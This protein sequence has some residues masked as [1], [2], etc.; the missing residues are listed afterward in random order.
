MALHYYEDFRSRDEENHAYRID[1][2]NH[3]SYSHGHAQIFQEGEYRITLNGNKHLLS[4]PDL[5]D[6][7]L[8]MKMT[9]AFR[10]IQ[11][12]YG[13]VW[14]FRYDRKGM[15]GHKLEMQFDPRHDMK[16]LLDGKTIGERSFGKLPPSK[17]M[18]AVLEVKGRELSFTAFGMTCK[19][20]IR[21]K[22]FPSAGAV[23]FDMLFSP[24]STAHIYSVQ[25]DSPD[26][27][28]SRKPEKTIEFVLST[29]QGMTEPLK[30][31]FS[32][33]PCGADFDQLDCVLDGSIRGRGDREDG[34][35]RGWIYEYDYLTS[36]YIR[37]ESEGK[38]L[39]NF[40]FR[41]GC[42]VLL[43]RDWKNYANRK[44]EDLPWPLHFTFIRRKL[45]GKYLVAAG[46]E[47]EKHKPW[48]FCENGPWEQIRDQEGNF[49]YEGPSL[50]K[51]SVALTVSSPEDKKIVSRIPRGI[52]QYE[53]ALKHAREQH[54]FYDDEKISFLL[55]VHYRKACYFRE[56][57]SLAC[58]VQDPYGTTVPGVRVRLTDADSPAGDPSFACIGK[59]AVLNKN[60]PC[61]IYHL[62]LL[63]KNGLKTFYDDV[64]IF[65][66]L[67]EDPAGPPPPL[68][69]GLP[70]MIS[71]NNEIKNLESDGFDPLGGWGGMG[72]YYT[73]VMR[74]PLVGGRLKIWELLKVYHR[75]WHLMLTRRNAGDFSLENEFNR[76]LIR[77]ADFLDKDVPEW[78]SHIGSLFLYRRDCHCGPFL[79]IFKEFLLKKKPPL[80]LTTPEI[81]DEMLSSDPKEL[82]AF[83]CYQRN[84]LS[85][86]QF[87][88]L[89]NTCWNEWVDFAVKAFRKRS[90]AFGKELLKINPKL[91]RGSYGPS[92]LYV[93]HYKSAYGARLAVRSHEYDEATNRN[94]SYFFIEE[95]HLSCD[96]TI[97]RSSYFIANCKL[98]RPEMRKLFPEIY[99]GGGLGCDD[100]AVYQAHPP[101]G[102]YDC[103]PQH[104]RSIVY[105][106]CYATPYFKNGKFD[107]WRDYGF[108]CPTPDKA[109]FREFIHAWG[110]LHRNPPARQLAAPFFCYDFRLFELLGD[111]HEDEYNFS[112]V[113]G[114]LEGWSDVV[115]TGEEAM[116]YAFIELTHNGYN[117]PVQTTFE[118]LS[119]L[120]KETAPFLVLP[121]IPEG[122]P[123]KILK[124]IRNAHKKGIGLL[125]FEKVC[126]LEDLFGVKESGKAKALRRIGE[127]VFHHK[128]AVASYVA[129]GAKVVK[130]G[131]ESVNGKDDVP[132][133]FF[134]ETS[135]GRT[136]L[137]NVPPTTVKRE[138]YRA[139]LG[140]GQDTLSGEMHDC[141]MQAASFLMPNP[142]SKSELGMLNAC[143]SEKGDVIVTVCGCTPAYGVTD[144]YPRSF[145]FKVSFPGIGK[146]GIETEA[147]FAV[148]KREKDSL[149]IRTETELDAGLFFRFVLKERKQA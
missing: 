94:G 30:F 87:D 116:G 70:M 57:F 114:V 3:S 108:H 52:P 89:V 149:L 34:G 20:V 128:K 64:E 68:A 98:M 24:G 17:N 72:H 14:Y 49:L 2:E 16:V 8:E 145:R 77:H 69:S 112:P 138:D 92:S 118:E 46:Y 59:K 74:Y 62:K 50:R 71:M 121:P 125:A 11:F 32:V 129:D 27:C 106:F 147:P 48:L 26:D 1:I 37:I 115:N 61:G 134:H 79:E 63:L 109:S 131:S 82:P 107:Y 36:P 42:M 137:F 88:E 81:I 18:K 65:E 73:L 96:Y 144:P 136:A 80:K 5:R 91:G 103:L 75:K 66:V 43:D 58:E 9:L 110:N 78:E 140:C 124:S 55:K 119:S 100:G 47:H 23:G 104:Q 83:F 141:M 29:V 133:L 97:V 93:Q 35:T 113:P 7:R 139:K 84:H 13:F 10:N 95:Y 25:L 143:L 21:E 146:A 101:F 6:F 90:I 148:L 142:A 135:T 56:E 38:E 19:G 132:V 122:T 41:K 111:Y 33:T 44:L 76:E 105:T 120:T 31:R 28:A 22:G 53:K 85:H 67:P 12:G 126:G 39:L 45:P 99:Y 130:K 123:E 15:T 102:I 86:E 54:Y 51:D 117:T 4:T 127:E 60:L 40:Y